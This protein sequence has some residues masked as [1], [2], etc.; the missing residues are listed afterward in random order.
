MNSN[1]S[2]TSDTYSL[3]VNFSD[4][5]DLKRNDEYVALSNLRH[6]LCM[7]KYKKVIQK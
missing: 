2:G 3:L 7:K 5:I 1:N 6:I 4:K